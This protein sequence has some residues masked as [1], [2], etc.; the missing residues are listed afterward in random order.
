MSN[1]RFG[2]IVAA[3]RKEFR[4]EFDEIMTQFDLAELSRIPLV[5]LQKI[6]QGRQSNLKPDLIR[7]LADALQLSAYARI[8]FYL[9]ALGIDEADHA[10]SGIPPQ[11]LLDD[12]TATLAQLQSP[13]FI[14]TAFGDLL[15]VNRSFLAVHGLNL[16]Q[17][18]DSRLLTRYN[19]NRLFFSPEFEAQQ[20]M[21]EHDGADFARRSVLLYKTITLHY[22][23]H[24]YFQRILPE[25][26]RF[27]LFRQY[28]QS[29]AFKGDDVNNISN[30][31][32]FTHPQYGPLRFFIMPL[33]VLGNYIDIFL[34]TY[35]PLDAA[36]AALCIRL[37]SELGTAPIPLAAW[38]G[39]SN[40]ERTRSFSHQPRAM[41][42]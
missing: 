17:I 35:Q 1:L 16:Q 26:N 20:K 24:S 21:L 36:S 4:N 23:G 6:E 13:A 10:S 3:L 8:N 32:S 38:P 27:P 42:K 7:K 5:T 29:P 15:Y 9:A 18:R 41:F 33:R 34:Y 12:L 39:D 19:I 2:Q 40:P 31:L 14:S 25:L 30:T 37:A 22:R 28:W 11:G